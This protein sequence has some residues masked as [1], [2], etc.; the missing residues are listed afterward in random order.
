MSKTNSSIAVQIFGLYCEFFVFG[1][2]KN[3]F[4]WSKLK[5]DLEPQFSMHFS[6][7]KKA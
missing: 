7:I 6:F 5:N 1:F 2:S 3:L 4:V